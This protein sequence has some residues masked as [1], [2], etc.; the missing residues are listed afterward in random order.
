MNFHSF[1]DQRCSARG[2]CG[3]KVY[4]LVDHAQPC[5]LELSS[6]M[7]A[8]FTCVPGRYKIVTKQ[9]KYCEFGKA[10]CPKLPIPKD[11][12]WE[13][14]KTN[15]HTTHGKV[16]SLNL[17]C[18]NFFVSSY[19]DMKCSGTVS[20]E[21]NIFELLPKFKPCPVELSSYLQASFTCLPGKLKV[22][23]ININYSRY[24]AKLC[25]QRMLR[26]KEYH[27]RSML[28]I[29]CLFSRLVQWNS[30]HILKLHFNV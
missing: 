23:I 16:L 3:I 30:L 18:L 1:T 13:F 26:K 12:C 27:V 22:T 4:E 7:E 25:R 15:F 21:I 10:K 5:P 19:C 20:C 14:I 29:L 8:S 11:S 2:S 6:Y 28:G 17:N 9:L 24:F